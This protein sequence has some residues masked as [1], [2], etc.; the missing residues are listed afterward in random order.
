MDGTGWE[1][2]G[3]ERLKW[4]VKEWAG[5]DRKGLECSGLAGHGRDRRGLERQ[6]RRG[7]ERIGGDW[8]GL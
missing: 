3:L 1:R 5:G 4:R 6:M 2:P 8:R 7:Q